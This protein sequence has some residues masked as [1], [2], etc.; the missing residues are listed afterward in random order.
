MTFP[1]IIRLGTADKSGGP[2]TKLAAKA[3]LIKLT[4]CAVDR[5]GF[6]PEKSFLLMS[7]A[8]IT[9]DSSQEFS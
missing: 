3:I 5:T 2:E 1:L 8:L 4:A 7:K 6:A 9:N